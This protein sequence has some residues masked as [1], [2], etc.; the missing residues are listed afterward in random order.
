MRDFVLFGG[1]KIYRA[2]DGALWK[3]VSGRGQITVATGGEALGWLMENI[4]ASPKRDVWECLL[5]SH[6]KA[7]TSSLDYEERK[8][9]FRERKHD[10]TERNKRVFRDDAPF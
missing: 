8:A 1:E 7:W 3:W 9:K 6:N 4:P 2:Y 5:A 10:G